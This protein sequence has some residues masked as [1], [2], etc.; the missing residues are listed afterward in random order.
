MLHLYVKKQAVLL[1]KDGPNFKVNIFEQHPYFKK[2]ED[3]LKLPN[4]D[5]V[6]NKTR[7][8]VLVFLVDKY[9]DKIEPF[10]VENNIEFVKSY[11][12]F[13][14]RPSIE[15]KEKDAQIIIE[16]HI[17]DRNKFVFKICELKLRGMFY[18]I[19]E[20]EKTFTDL[21]LMLVEIHKYIK[22]GPPSVSKTQPTVEERLG[23][24]SLMPYKNILL[25]LEKLSL[26]T[27]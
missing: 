9:P 22:T 25:Q 27:E 6:K 26:Y 14:L 18:P 4:F 24:N 17:A 10:L 2:Y 13:L 11:G 19:L 23:C 5:D 16:S 12:E 3:L 20:S 15:F 7:I 21:G 1:I 8:Q